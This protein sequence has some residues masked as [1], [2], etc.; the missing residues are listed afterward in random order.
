VDRDART[1]TA[2]PTTVRPFIT[3]DQAAPAVNPMV[4]AQATAPK[5]MRVARATVSRDMLPLTMIG[6]RDPAVPRCMAVQVAARAQAVAPNHTTIGRPVLVAPVT[7]LKPTLVAPREP[8]LGARRAAM[9]PKETPT[10]RDM[11][12]RGMLPLTMID[13]RD[14]A[15]PRCMAAPVAGRA[16]AAASNHTTIGRLVLVVPVT[17]LKPTLADRRAAMVSSRT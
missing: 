1:H 5:G 10:A 17:T 3:T 8:T 12:S 4:A 7:T 11:V 13:R 9:A 16:Q 15:V 14:L 6:R 2:D